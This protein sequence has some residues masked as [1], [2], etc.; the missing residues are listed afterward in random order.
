MGDV[1]RTYVWNCNLALFD[2]GS[3]SFALCP[4]CSH[5]SW[6]FSLFILCLFP[7]SGPQYMAADNNIQLYLKKHFLVHTLKIPRVRLRYCP[8]LDRLLHTGPYELFNELQDIIYKVPPLIH[9]MNLGVCNAYSSFQLVD[10]QYIWHSMI[11][12][13]NLAVSAPYSTSFDCG[14]ACIPF[15]SQDDDLHDQLSHAESL[16]KYIKAYRQHGQLCLGTSIV[17]LCRRHVLANDSIVIVLYA[18]QQ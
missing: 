2:S 13:P 4:L 16:G 7:F 17:L 15:I 5:S 6:C 14:A 12:K 8:I 11:F 9:Y 1:T 3:C 18:T 10:G